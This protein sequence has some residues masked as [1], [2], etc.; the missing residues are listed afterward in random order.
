MAARKKTIAKKKGAK[1]AATESAPG[2]APIP[3]NP[4]PIR[5]PRPIPIPVIFSVTPQIA[6]LSPPGA[7]VGTG[8]IT[9]MVLGSNFGSQTTVTWDQAARTTTAISATQVNAAITAADLAAI[10]DASVQVF[11]PAIAAGTAPVYSNAVTFSIIPDISAIMAQLASSTSTPPALISQLNTYI[12]LQQN[13]INSLNTQVQSD[14]TTQSDLNSQISTLQATVAQQ[15]TTITTLQA[16]L[17]ASKA[18][19]ASPLDV[20]QSFKSVVDTIRQAAQGGG[21]VQTTVSNLNVQ[22]KSLVSIQPAT[23]TAPAAANLI[24]PDPTALPD[25]QHLSTLSLSFGAVPNLTA[26]ASPTPG[27][28]PAPA[29]GPAPAPAPAATRTSGPSPVARKPA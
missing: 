16:Q 15:Q 22:L 11:N 21:G 29:P 26:A 5:P 28:A 23:A 6:S 10:Q 14:A 20:A 7:V 25:P 8:D 9:L 1:T 17:Q 13:Q 24:F 19:T 4:I 12:T 27:P 2:A 3:V 18:S